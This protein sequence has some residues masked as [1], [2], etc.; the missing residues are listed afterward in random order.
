MQKRDLLF[1]DVIRVIGGEPM[2]RGSSLS[3]LDFVQD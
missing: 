3:A 1:L 2:L